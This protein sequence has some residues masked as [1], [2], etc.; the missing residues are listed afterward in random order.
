MLTPVLNVPR[1]K[2]LK[3]KYD[4]LLKK[5]S[6]FAFN[7]KL[8]RYNQVIGDTRPPEVTLY[9]PKISMLEYGVNYSAAGA[10]PFAPCS[11]AAALASAASLNAAGAANATQ[12]PCALSALDD[13][14]GDVTAYFEAVS[15]TRPLFASP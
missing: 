8:R 4:K 7:F 10:S 6:K 1:T 15:Y 3:L 14:D 12:Y 13:A 5:K 9:I 2:R 11:T